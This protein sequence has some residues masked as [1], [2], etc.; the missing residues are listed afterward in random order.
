MNNPKSPKKNKS[1]TCETCSNY[2]YD[3]D[4]EEYTCMVNLDEDEY[5][6]FISETNYSCPYYRLDDEYKIA[7]KQ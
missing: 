5:A 2:V 3:E 6:R 4:W 7:R 1:T